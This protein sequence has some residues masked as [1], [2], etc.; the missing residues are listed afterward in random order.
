MSHQDGSTIFEHLV[1]K[2]MDLS[3]RMKS[4]WN[5]HG[6]KQESGEKLDYEATKDETYNLFQAAYFIDEE[7]VQPI[8]INE[9][10]EHGHGDEFIRRLEEAQTPLYPGCES[11]TKL[12]AIVDLYGLKGK[13]GLSSKHFNELLDSAVSIKSFLKIFDMGYEKIHACVNDCC[14]FRKKYEELD[15]CPTCGASRWKI[16]KRSK[17]IR[18]GVPVKVLRYFPIIPRFKRM[19]RSSQMAKDLRWHFDNKSTDGKMRHPVDSLAWDLVNDKWPSFA[20]DPHNL[21]LGLATDGFNPFS[22]LSSKYSCWPV[23]LVNYNLP[24]M[25]CMKKDNIML[26]LLIPGPKQPG[27]DIDIYLQPLVDDLQLLWENGVEAYDAFS[28]STF[29]LKTM[30]M[31]TINDFPAYGNLAGCSTKGRKACPI[32]GKIHIIEGGDKKRKRNNNENDGDDDEDEDDTSDIDNQNELTRWKKRSI[33]FSLPYWKELVLRH[34][35]DVMHIEKNICESI[36]STMLHSGKSKDGI[37]ARKDLED[38]GIRKDLHPEQ[39]GSR[40]YLPPAPHTFSRS[41]KK[42]FCKRIY[43]FKGP[44]GYCS[45]IGNC[46][47]LEDCKI[48]RLKSHDYHVLMQQLLAI[49]IRG[50]LPKEPRKAII[51]LSRFFNRLCQRAIDREKLLDLENEIIETLCQLERFIPPSFFDIMIPIDS[52]DHSKTLRWLAYGPKKSALSCKGYI[53][54]GLRFHTKDV[55]RETQNSGVTYDAITMCRASAK[56]TAQVAHLDSYYGILTDIILLDYHLFY[57]LL[58]KCHWANKGNGVKEEDGFTLVN[59]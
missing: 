33:F 20:A 14:L 35:L 52:N 29:N 39:R 38:I 5:K 17:E 7:L 2:G 56:D 19:F 34:N 28:K 4:H 10:S 45:N 43:D 30:L 50:L 55:D 53:I 58:F 22:I 27:N 1:T 59:L 13:S 46:I 44:D 36:I 51:R 15:Y 21:R 37:N 31:W 32:C 9:P 18:K 42:R 3:Y 25:L 24:P 16:N 41:E 48:M 40:L 23:M 12:S 57:V 8:P 6:E 26:T 54:N 11:Y 47:T 49:A